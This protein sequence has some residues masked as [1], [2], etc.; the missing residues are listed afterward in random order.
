MQALSND[1]SLSQLIIDDP[2]AAGASMPLGFLRSMTV[3]DPAIEPEDFDV[4]P[5]LLAHP[6]SDRMTDPSIS[7]QFFDR[8]S[9]SKELVWL[10]NA[11]HIPIEKPGI[12]QLEE[13]IR[14]LLVERVGLQT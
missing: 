10:E 14:R 1:A 7:L 4:C 3:T 6:A 9:G 2:L 12:D 13:S 11:G 5:L 8:L